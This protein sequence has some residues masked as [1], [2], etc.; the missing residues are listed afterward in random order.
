M[1][2][3]IELK[4]SQLLR[5]LLVIEDDIDLDVEADL[6]QQIG[7]DSIEAFD[8]VAT[9]HEIIGQPIPNDFNPKV[10]NSV[11]LLAKYVQ[12]QFGDAGVQK[13]L[14]VD[15]DAIVSPEADEAL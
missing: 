15:I 1:N 10:S 8:A 2:N 12:D 6:V 4:I 3:A 13:V 14:A 9:V 5:R 7:L 11:R